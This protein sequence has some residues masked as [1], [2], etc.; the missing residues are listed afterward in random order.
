MPTW[1]DALR[2]L[3]R[4]RREHAEPDETFWKAVESTLPF[5][6]N[7]PPTAHERVRRLAARFLA[8]KTFYGAHGLLITDLI[9]GSIA[10]QA[11]LVAHRTGL[12]IYD[13]F[14]GVIVYP[15]P[16]RVRRHLADEIGLVH[17]FDDELY[18]ETW[19]GGPVIV[20]WGAGEAEGMQVVLH[21]FAHRLDL[22][23]GALDGVPLL[24]PSLPRARWESVMEDALRRLQDELDA[25]KSPPLDPYAE[26]GPEEF[27]PV[28]TETFFAQPE[29][30]A[31]WDPALFAAL[32]E[33]YGMYPS[34]SDRA[35][36]H[37]P[38]TTRSP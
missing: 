19:E 15:E 4:S 17:E 33:V 3:W 30:L 31:A 35:T 27:F 34:P 9:A 5:L 22:A 29:A 11:A 10:W 2:R 25:G 7:I 21:E 13:D 38:H 32:C 36:P 14:V 12:G 28:A 24:P 6:R 37:G 20:S 23:D 16:F 18:G 1:I 8:T 26:E